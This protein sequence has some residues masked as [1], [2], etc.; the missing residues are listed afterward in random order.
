MNKITIKIFHIDIQNAI[1]FLLGMVASQNV[2]YVFKISNTY[3]N[4]FQAFAAIVLTLNLFTRPQ[5]INRSFQ[6]VDKYFRL[7][8]ILCFVSGVQFVI[9]NVLFLNLRITSYFSGIVTYT[10]AL[11]Y[12]MC[13]ILY[14]DQLHSVIR[15]LYAGFIINILICFLQLYFFSRGSFFSLYQFFPQEFYYVSIPWE[16]R[17]K[18]SSNSSLIYS[19]RATG[20]FLET[21][22]FISYLSIIILIFVTRIKKSVSQI[23]LILLISIFVLIS[24]SGTFLAYILSF[25]IYMVLICIFFGRN[26][27][28]RGS[29]IKIIAGILA[30]IIAGALLGNKIMSSVFHLNNITDYFFTSLQTASLLNSD[31]STRL[32]YMVN[33]LK[34]IEKYPFGVGCNMAPTL[35]NTLYGTYSTFNYFLSILLELGPLGIIVYC[36]FLLKNI[37]YEIK[38]A[39]DKYDIALATSMIVIGVLQFANGIGLTSYVLLL[40]ALCRIRIMERRD[41]K[42]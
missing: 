36:T 10:L 9:I 24:G 7:F 38:Y 21:S 32:T 35:L 17:N 39:L 19:Y 3:I 27:I 1:A 13:I 37:I 4:L 28:S 34:A 23:I 41:A 12:Y 14:K 22:H 5:K 15:G 2:V 25:A 40:F 26:V 31:N 33:A 11:M 16:S 30:I 18:L 29:Y 20:M 6:C 42:R 8:W